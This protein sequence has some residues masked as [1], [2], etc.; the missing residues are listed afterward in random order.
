M[1]EEARPASRTSTSLLTDNSIVKIP[2]AAPAAQPASITKW[3]TA[4]APAPTGMSKRFE[5]KQIEPSIN[6]VRPEV[7]KAYEEK[8]PKPSSSYPDWILITLAYS[9]VFVLILLM[10]NITP[11]GKLYIHFTAFWSMILYFVIDDVDHTSTDVLDTVMENF[12]KVK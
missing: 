9:V 3:P 12:V 1:R 4:A 10:S 5:A 7:A 11:N 8:H 6:P 2:P